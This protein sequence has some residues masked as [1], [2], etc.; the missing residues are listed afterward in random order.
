MN[1]KIVTEAPAWFLL[2]CILA[3]AMYAAVLYRRDK[4]N[5]ALSKPLVA[6]LSLLR[7][8]VVSGIAFLLMSPLL[9]TVFREVEKPVIVIAA[10]HSESVVANKDSAWYRTEFPAAL[11]EIEKALSENYTVVRYSFGDHF[12][13]GE[14][15]AFTH[16]ETDLS[17]LFDE[18]ETRY[19]D[20][21][22]GAVVLA[23]DGIYNRGSGPLIAA[24]WLKSPLFCIA[25][26]DT[27]VKKDVRIVKVRHNSVAF[28]GNK[29][30]VEVIVH[31]DKCMG[32][33]ISV[34]LSK[35]GQQLAA[36]RINVNADVFTTTVPFELQ[37]AN[38]GMQKYSVSVTSVN[39]DENTAN[40]RQDFFVEVLDSR[41]KILIVGAAPHPDIAALKL[42]I[43]SND[44]YEVT[45]ALINDLP[46]EINKFN[47]AILHSVPSESVQGQKLLSELDL[48]GIPIWYITGVQ[49]RYNAFNSRK[50][51]I[52]IE[53]NGS[54]PNDCQPVAVRDFPLFSLS[55]KT[56][57][58]F[59]RMPA[60]QV[61]FAGF[62][63]SNSVSVLLNQKIGSLNTDYPLMSF[64]EQNGRKN[65]VF[66]GEGIWRWRLNDFAENGN[67]DAFNEFIGKTIQY[68]SLAEEKSFFRVT[69]PNSV[70]ENQRT[71]FDAE[72]YNKSFE[73]VQNADVFLD[74]TDEEGRRYNNTFS[75]TTR[76]YHLEAPL[77]S[78]GEYQWEARTK[79]G[80]EN[81]QKKGKFIVTPLLAERVVTTANHR[82]LNQL[83]MAHNGKLIYPKETGTLTDL[84]KAR[85][86]IRPVVYNPQ[87][88]VDLVQLPWIFALLMGLLT[89]EWFIRKRNGAY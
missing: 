35:G 80:T 9:K 21:N 10:D 47:L 89:L 45:T 32:E 83:C 37:A 61:P 17:Q 6:F 77:L 56:M 12:S 22:L 14:D 26:G 55:D 79:L 16:K 69:A 3:G 72:V 46:Q 50:T 44:N 15:S 38:V 85:E 27:T 49:S 41:Q 18:L 65:A 40:N 63:K 4:K 59:Q 39:G 13:E 48:T 2:L 33:N 52:S 43:E 60:V 7:F 23:S 31:A 82:I 25:L 1:I 29:F 28:L 19:S 58:W 75:K 68:L 34:V 70:Q 57:N 88:M 62:E 11:S 76:A 36:Q 86:D 73:L 74:I 87:K 64:T 8:T 5:D 66:C 78:P 81:Y 30:P 20:R 84:I 67:H 24:E 71:S 53:M 51:G 54:R 42:S